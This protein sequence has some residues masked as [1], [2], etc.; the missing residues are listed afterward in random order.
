MPAESSRKVIASGFD[1]RTDPAA[2]VIGP[3]GVGLGHD[4]KLYVADT[5]ANSVDTISDALFRTTDAGTGATL[6]SAVGIQ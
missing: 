1:E 3:T 6:S 2:L 5:A 4:G